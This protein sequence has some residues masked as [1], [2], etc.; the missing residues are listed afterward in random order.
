MI[1]LLLVFLGGFVGGVAWSAASLLFGRR[2]RPE[3]EESIH[4]HRILDREESPI[5]KKSK[6]TMWD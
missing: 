4:D 2:R 1:D 6:R 3:S 5:P